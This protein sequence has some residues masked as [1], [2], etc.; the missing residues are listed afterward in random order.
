MWPGPAARA[1]RRRHRGV[2][3]GPH[4]RRDG[5]LHAAA[6]RAEQHGR[7]RSPARSSTTE[8]VEAIDAALGDWPPATPS[9]WIPAVNGQGEP[10]LAVQYKQTEQAHIEMAVH[11]CSSQ[12]PDRFA[13]DLISVILGEGMSSRLFLELREK[14]ALCYDVHS[15]ASHYLDDGLV[16]RLRRRRSVEGGGGGRGAAARSWRRCAT[17]ASRDE[18][19]H[20]AKELSKGRLLLRMEDTRNVSGWLGGQEMLNGDI[21]TPDEIVALVDA[22][23]MDD[24]KR[25]AQRDHDE[26]PALGRDRGARS[27]RTS[28]FRALRGSVALAQQSARQLSAQ[29]SEQR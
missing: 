2:G 3:D 21:K 7:R 15:Y 24:V 22:V 14:R 6:V 12:H 19:L 4:A 27:G 28:A 17:T 5:R 18:E 13:I 20:K 23:T 29:L 25:V 1:G 9:P 26:E 10:R 11:G 16:R 8:I